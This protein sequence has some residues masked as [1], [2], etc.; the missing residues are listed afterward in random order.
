MQETATGIAASAAPQVE[1]PSRMQVAVVGALLLAVAV[2][3]TIGVPHVMRLQHGVE[4][5]EWLGRVARGAAIYYVKPRG[6]EDGQRM[7]CQFPRGVAKVT[8]AESCCDPR[9]NLP[10][11]SLCDPAKLDWNK[12]I[13]NA[14]STSV[15]EPQPF[16][17]VYEAAGTFADAKYQI[18][19]Y[20][21]I[22]CDGVFSTFR[23]VG[24]GDP[25]A[26]ADD[27]VLKTRPTFEFH[28]ADE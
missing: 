14:L 18:S 5:M 13:W 21:D 9:V 20:A 11:T 24:Q 2:A 3:L 8:D 6:T 7:A 10:G 17:W 16:I 27:C 26:K 12:P 23:M 19:A 15:G 1:R 28:R 4:A 22:D 25:Q